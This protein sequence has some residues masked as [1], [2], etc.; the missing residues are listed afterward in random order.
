MSYLGPLVILFS[1][2]MYIPVHAQRATLKPSFHLNYTSSNGFT[3]PTKD[4]PQSKMWY[5]D[6][7]WWAV[8][9]DKLGATLWE[10]TQKGWR[11]H[12]EVKKDLNGVPG[13]ADVWYEDRIATAVGVSDS[14]LCVFRLNPLDVSNQKWKAEIL[15]HLVLP[16]E[17][18]PKIETA[19]IAKD[20]M[21]NWWIAADVGG[22]AIYVWNSENGK[23]WSS[24]MLLVEGISPDDIC[25]ITTLDS[26]IIVIWSNQTGEF[27]VDSRRH[28]NG[29]PMDQWSVIHRIASGDR[30][31]DDHIHTVVSEDGTLWVNT[32]NSVDKVGHPQL[33]LRIR[34]TQGKWKNFPYYIRRKYVVPS[35]PVI[36]TVENNPHLLLAGNTIYDRT[37][38]SSVGSISFGIID[39]TSSDILLRRT[40]V[41]VPDT[42]LGLLVNDITTSKR[43]FPADGPWIILA[44]DYRGNVYEANLRPFFDKN[45]NKMMSNKKV[46][47]PIVV[48][49]ESLTDTDD[50]AIWINKKD[51]GSSLILGTDKDNENG[52]LYVY[53]LDGKINRQK[54]VLGMKDANNVDVAYGLDLNGE[55]VD[56]A[57]VTERY[58]HRLRVFSLP[59]MEPIDDG[60]IPVFK[61]E[62][63]HQPMG[64]G[65]YTRPSDHQIFAIVSRKKGP[66]ENY[67]AQYLL[68]DNGEG[69]VTGKL[70][71]EFGKY[72]GKQEIESI[73]VDNELG[74]VYYSDERA[75]IRKYYADPKKGNQE[76]A[77]FGQEDF[78]RDEEGISIY[79]LTDSTGYII[80]SD[81]QAN[82]FNVYPREGKG[83]RH[84]IYKKILSIPLPALVSDG[85]EVTNVSLPGYPSGL[86]VA[87]SDDKTFQLYSWQDLA[88]QYGLLIDN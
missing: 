3:G 44:S 23:D 81:Q 74:Y 37:S 36:Q 61:G 6:H 16:N 45:Y 19:T 83:P 66:H 48:T 82:R 87:M 11:E 71:R 55:K 65:L 38:R 63:D 2:C 28:V 67:L 69:Q 40:N 20:R 4:K 21:G 14:S 73:A 15:S 75:G 32:K 29:Q 64:I 8:L 80:V 84:N 85:S 54:T 57:V 53:D 58:A 51:R 49:E 79:K 50:P 26:S 78:T 9:P 88:E 52:G 35:R 18:K 70:V 25:S 7:R 24:A 60:G 31:A 42:S 72:S 46:V 47:K 62:E 86:F 13:Q 76:L 27:Y 77:F 33:V 17:T 12:K 5:M 34:S 10:R 68:K 43:P 1:L 59:D 56:I 22:E 41:I 30:T 39:T